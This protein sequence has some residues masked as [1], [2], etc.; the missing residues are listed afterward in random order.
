MVNS[1]K[2]Y[3]LHWNHVAMKKNIEE[4]LFFIKG[5]TKRFRDFVFGTM[6]KKKIER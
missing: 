5:E 2:E 1:K 6:H 3:I 4:Y